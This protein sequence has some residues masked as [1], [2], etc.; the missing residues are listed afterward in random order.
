[1]LGY[2]FLPKRWV[3]TYGSFNW[4]IFSVLGSFRL[5]AGSFSLTVESMPPLPH[6]DTSVQVLG[7]NQLSANCFNSPQ[8]SGG[9]SGF[10][11]DRLLDLFGKRFVYI[12]NI[13]IRTYLSIKAFLY[14]RKSKM[15][16][17]KPVYMTLNA[18]LSLLTLANLFV[19]PLDHNL[20]TQFFWMF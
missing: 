18:L 3:E 11:T 16:D 5:V 1:M 4:V 6:P 13:Y 20:V 12:S 10:H 2:F 15:C 9:G 14:T 17:N 19:T 8:V 7:S